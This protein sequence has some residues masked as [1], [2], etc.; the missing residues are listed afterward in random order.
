MLRGSSDILDRSIGPPVYNQPWRF[1]LISSKKHFS[2]LMN[3]HRY[4]I[5]THKECRYAYKCRH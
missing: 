5:L 4:E 3:T 1:F 2:C